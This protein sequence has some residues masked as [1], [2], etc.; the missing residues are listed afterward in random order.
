MLL[1][2]PYISE[3]EAE[4]IIKKNIE[5]IN[6]LVCGTLADQSCSDQGGGK[7]PINPGCQCCVPER[8]CLETADPAECE[9]VTGDP[10]VDCL[11]PYGSPP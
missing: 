8:F 7:P 11:P 3:K 2:N 1:E 5:K 9:P 10:G 6:N 4:E